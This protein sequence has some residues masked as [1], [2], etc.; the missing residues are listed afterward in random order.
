[1]AA[2]T[3][4]TLLAT[5][6]KNARKRL[7]YSQMKLAELCNVSTSY[8]GEIEISRKY[9]SAETLQKI[10]DALGL[11]PYQLFLDEEAW[12]IFDKRESILSLY[13][14]LREKINADLEDTVKKHLK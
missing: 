6:M 9:P 1:M 7:G 10:A 13:D 12:M 8:I 4:Q 14:E 5:N 11:K 2:K 3:V